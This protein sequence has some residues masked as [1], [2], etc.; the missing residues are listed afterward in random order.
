MKIKNLFLSFLLVCIIITS[1]ACS[2]NSSKEKIH[3]Y[4]WGEYIDPSTIKDFEKETGI[5]VIYDTFASNEDMYIKVKQGSDKYDVLVPSDYMIERMI[6]EN[7]LQPINFENIP[8]FKNVN[9]ELLNPG[10]DPEN[11]YSVPYFWGTL[12][13]VYNSE[14]INKPITK[15]AD[16]WDPQFKNQIIM[17]NSQR[18]SIAI[19]L[20]KLGYSMNTT[21]E[22]ELKQ[23]EEELKKQKPLVYAYLTDDGRD[24]LVQG[25][26]AMGVFY[27]GDALLM[28]KENSDLKYVLP[29]EGTNLWYDSFV[30]P[31]NAQNVSGAEKFIDFMSRPDIAARNAEHTVGYSSPITDAIKLLPEDIS[32]SEVAYPDLSKLNNLEVYKDPK[33]LIEVYDRIWT[34]VTSDQN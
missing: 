23:A 4:N 26:A 31:S 11:K 3:V 22:E 13:I 9:Q 7:L 14:M 6:N 19:A 17:Y 33:A 24:V 28:M 15:W 21:N 12:G 25:D 20:K 5:T 29:E 16:L 30:I 34:E 10:Y 18:D 2:G 1:T 8:N 27:S 32:T